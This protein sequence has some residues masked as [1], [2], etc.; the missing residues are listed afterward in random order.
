M[1]R[2]RSPRKQKKTAKNKTAT[3]KK[4]TIPTKAAL[5]QQRETM[6]N[7]KKHTCL[8][9]ICADED[10][11]GKNITGP[12]SSQSLYFL[13]VPVIRHPSLVLFAILVT[14]AK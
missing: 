14:L 8:S 3:K 12:D 10:E 11:A 4:A 13:H 9:G 5:Q 6:Q 2:A 7:I 1:V